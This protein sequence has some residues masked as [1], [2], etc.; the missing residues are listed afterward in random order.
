MVANH[1]LLSWIRTGFTKASQDL[2]FQFWEV[3][4]NNAYFTEWNR[5]KKKFWKLFKSSES[6]YD[7]DCSQSE[8]TDSAEENSHDSKRL[9]NLMC[10]SSA[11]I[12]NGKTEVTEKNWQTEAKNWQTA[13]RELDLQHLL[14]RKPC[15]LPFQEERTVTVDVWFILRANYMHIVKGKMQKLIIIIFYI[16]FCYTFKVIKMSSE[17][18]FSNLPVPSQK[19]MK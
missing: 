17:N 13:E 15:H 8:S 5:D 9:K 12:S 11:T 3:H 14:K 7:P 19:K 2:C 6:E 10:S 1:C 4:V 18:K 16:G